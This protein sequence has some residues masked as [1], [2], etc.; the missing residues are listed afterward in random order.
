MLVSAYNEKNYDYF[1]KFL[2]ELL[3]NNKREDSEKQE[4]LDVNRNDLLELKKIFL[5][6]NSMTDE[7]KSKLSK[8]L[9]RNFSIT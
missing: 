7:E 5:S 2:T 1:N 6:N 8:K 3:E 4:M 9:I